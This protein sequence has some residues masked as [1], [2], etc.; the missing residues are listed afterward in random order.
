MSRQGL[1]KKR[2]DLHL[3][4]GR[5]H[6][7]PSQRKAKWGENAGTI[8]VP[9]TH[10]HLT[11]RKHVMCARNLGAHVRRSIRSTYER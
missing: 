1:A 6:E 10:E 4:N 9:G 5:L 7:K 11:S 8:F 3:L 2:Y